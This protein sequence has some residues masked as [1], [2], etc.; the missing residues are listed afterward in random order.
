V[1]VRVF[2]CACVRVCVC[3]CVCKWDRERRSATISLDKLYQFK[4]Y[5]E[6]ATALILP[7]ESCNQ[8]VRL[9]IF[10][11]QLLKCNLCFRLLT[12]KKDITKELYRKAKIKKF[13]DITFNVSKTV[14]ITENKTPFSRGQK[15]TEVFETVNLLCFYFLVLS[16]ILTN[17]LSQT[18]CWR[19]HRFWKLA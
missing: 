9:Q 6:Y 4:G 16:R 8:Y 13:L 19:R 7:Y 18:S 3:A 10:F 5:P 1:C 12:R 11:G 15:C 17:F 2:V 14:L